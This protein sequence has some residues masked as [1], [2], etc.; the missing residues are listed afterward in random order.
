MAFTPPQ[1]NFLASLDLRTLRQDPSIDDDTLGFIQAV[2]AF[3]SGAELT[4]GLASRLRNVPDS[5]SPEAVAGL[6]LPLPTQIFDQ[7][8][9]GEGAARAQHPG[10]EPQGPPLITYQ[11]P[12]SGID[13]DNPWGHLVGNNALPTIDGPWS[14]LDMM[15]LTQLN[16]GGAGIV[17]AQYTDP[18][19]LSDDYMNEPLNIAKVIPGGV[20]SA[21]GDFDFSGLNFSP[22]FSPSFAPAVRGGQGG[23]V[24]F[25]ALTS[26][27]A[28]DAIK[29][30]F[31]PDITSLINFGE[32]GIFGP[33]GAFGGSPL[34]GQ[35]A[36][37]G[38]GADAFRGQNDFSN[39]IPEGGLLQQP[40]VQYPEGGLVQFPDTDFGPA[41]DALFS[42]LNQL[43]RSLDVGDPRFDDIGL[44]LTGLEQVIDRLNQGNQFDPTSLDFLS[45]PLQSIVDART[46]SLD[47]ITP[48]AGGETPFDLTGAT[49]NLGAVGPSSVQDL[50]APLLDLPFIDDFT[51]F[52]QEP[53]LD[54]VVNDLDA[55]N[56]FDT[57]RDQV[58]NDVRFGINQDFD[59]ELENL[60]NRQGV[61]NQVGTASA[62]RDLE[63]FFGRK[64]RAL[65]DA[66]SQFGLAAANADIGLRGERL[67]RLSGVLG[68]EF[69]RT[70]QQLD[71]QNRLTNQA[72]QDFT[73]LIGAFQGQLDA[74][75]RLNDEGLR[76]MLGGIGSTLVPNATAASDALGRVS[77]ATGA[78]Q[79][80]LQSNLTDAFSRF[81]NRNN[82][83][84]AA[85]IR[86]PY[87][88]L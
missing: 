80:G 58:L 23:Q 42:R 1:F 16:A 5:I 9:V 46:E 37:T 77:E 35:D 3:R 41:F 61:L 27:V 39:F 60:V 33:G 25:S 54:A 69:N 85:Q 64:A 75:Q 63:D 29:N 79:A 17:P 7:L 51:P 18:G 30:N 40:L 32:Q 15:G 34:I 52:L 68:D 48:F 10:P 88:L 72:N 20:K 50:D 57:R 70:Q 4:E 78:R 73:G 53:L 45:T 81:S 86:D 65:S 67:G 56:P 31:L 26:L 14:P 13:I 8:R 49:S 36:V 59:R 84:Q 47:P 2:Q 83:A 43:Q 44:Q 76:L 6:D 82:P 22:T 38:V 24:D 19:W 11:A 74:G 87:Y 66:G 12:G 71:F 55:P 28:P 21:A 62:N